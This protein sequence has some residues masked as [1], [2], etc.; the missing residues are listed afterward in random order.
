MTE[1]K[2][3]YYLRDFG[4]LMKELALKAK[5]NKDHSTKQEFDYN[6]GYLMALHDIIS[7]MKRQALSF[8]INET[9][10][11]IEDINPEKDIL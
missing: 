6:L 7:L 3:K 10:I 2:Y 1:K 8:D 4:C 9:D 5:F 11:C